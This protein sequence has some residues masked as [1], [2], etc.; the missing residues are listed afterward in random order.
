MSL[1]VGMLMGVFRVAVVIIRGAAGITSHGTGMRIKAVGEEAQRVKEG[2][3]EVDHGVVVTAGVGKMG[4][5]VGEMAVEVVEEARRTEV[6]TT[7]AVVFRLVGGTIMAVVITEVVR[8]EGGKDITAM[9]RAKA[10]EAGKMMEMQTT[11]QLETAETKRS[12][13]GRKANT[14]GYQG[15]RISENGIRLAPGPSVSLRANAT[16]H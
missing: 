8:V 9:A 4:M 6:G 14:T 3:G 1:G 15:C 16:C 5:A 11:R 2:V 12:G 13:S 7:A 10:E